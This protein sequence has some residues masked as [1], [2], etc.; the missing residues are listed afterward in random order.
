M[1]C[2]RAA[3]CNQNCAI[4]KEKFPD[5]QCKE[6]I[7]NEQ[8]KKQTELKE[9]KYLQIKKKATTKNSFIDIIQNST[10]QYI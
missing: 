9:Q 4:N 7:L 3:R 2:S 5:R 1:I 6:E 10:P 8:L